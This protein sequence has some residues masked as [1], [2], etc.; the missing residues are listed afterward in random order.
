MFFC[1][2]KLFIYLFHIVCELAIG[3]L[4]FIFRVSYSTVFIKLFGCNEETM[5]KLR[6]IDLS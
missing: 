2:M 6:F 4:I 5:K 3:K 1:S